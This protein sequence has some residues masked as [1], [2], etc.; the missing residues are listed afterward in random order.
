MLPQP[1]AGP[2]TVSDAVPDGASDERADRTK[3]CADGANEPAHEKA[4][5]ANAPAH[6]AAFRGANAPAHQAAQQ[7][8]FRGAN[9]G[10]HEAAL[11][12]ADAFADGEAERPAVAAVGGANQSPDL[13]NNRHAFARP[14]NRIAHIRP[15]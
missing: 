9:A 3:Q 12:G 6:E 11:Q 14:D 7:G 8:S 15:D 5:R 10:A 1:H 13:A 2:D 4:D